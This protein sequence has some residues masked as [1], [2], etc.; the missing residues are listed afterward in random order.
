MGLEVRGEDYLLA[1]YDYKTSDMAKDITAVLMFWIL[2]ILVNCAA[3]ELLELE[4][5]V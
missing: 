5:G 3:M 4:S 1:H 2:Y